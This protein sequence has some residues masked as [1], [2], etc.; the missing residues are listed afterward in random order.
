MQ[1]LLE[2]SQSHPVLIILF[3]GLLTMLLRT[4]VGSALAKNITNME[5]VK[6]INKD[7][8]WILDVRTKDEYDKTHIANSTH[9]PLDSLGQQLHQFE[10]KKKAPVILVCRSGNRSSQ[11]ARILKKQAFEKIY[12]LTEGLIGWQ[13]ANL[14]VQSGTGKAKDQQKSQTKKSGK[15]KRKGHQPALSNDAKSD[16]SDDTPTVDA[17]PEDNTRPEDNISMATPESE[18]GQQQPVPPL[19]AGPLTN[20]IYVYTAGYCPYT[21][22]VE[23]LLERKGIKYQQVDVDDDPAMRDLVFSKSNQSTFPQVFV[24]EQRVGNCDELHQMEREGQLESVLGIKPGW[25]LPT[26][27]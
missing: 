24:G 16:N 22:K 26:L 19:D 3:L 15:A 8:A 7:G 2:F 27:S 14:P 21:T 13:A 18:Q 5:A 20:N 11:A 9:V 6:L 17:R 23:R 10:D 1:Q 25:K 12:N 4:F